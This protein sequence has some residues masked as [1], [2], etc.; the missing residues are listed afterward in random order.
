[1]FK[2]LLQILWYGFW[3]Y[4]WVLLGM[5]ILITFGS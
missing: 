3:L 4:F 2:F 1:M 5:F